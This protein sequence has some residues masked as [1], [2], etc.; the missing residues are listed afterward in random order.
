M[1]DLLVADLDKETTAAEVE[2]KNS[3]EDSEKLMADAREA[4]TRCKVS[5]GKELHKGRARGEVL[6]EK[7]KKEATGKELMAT[8]EFISSL[9][10]ECDW[11]VQYS[12]VRKEGR[13]GEVESLQKAK[14]VLSGSDYSLIQTVKAHVRSQQDPKGPG[15]PEPIMGGACA[16][17]AKHAPYLNRK[18]QCVC[19]ATDIMGTFAD[20]A[21][22]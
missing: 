8:L 4:C 10:A 16:E 21:T 18:D 19:F 13:A 22:K 1:V 9:H 17:C 6:Q 11:P 14:A 5:H 20:D 15:H 7:D 12:R 2:E 3:Q